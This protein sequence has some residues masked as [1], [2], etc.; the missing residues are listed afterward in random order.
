LL[1]S[2]TSQIS[3]SPRVAARSTSRRDYATLALGIG[4]LLLLTS[5]PY[6]YGSL[7]SP[8]DRHFMGIVLDVPDTAQYFAWLRAHQQALLVS[9]WMTPEPNQPAFFNLLW[10]CLGRLA[11]WTGMGLAES[12][13][14]LR[15]VAGAAFGFALFWLYGLLAE[16]RRER[17]M[18][19]VLVLVGGGIGWI[20]V[21]EKYIAKRSDL[22][23]PLDVQVAE[24]NALL[25]M[26]GYPHFLLAAAFVLA[27]FGLFVVGV[28]TGRM[29]VYL[30][31]G[32]LGLALGLQHAYDLIT[33]YFVLGAFVVLLW[34]SQKRFPL[35]EAIGLVLIGLVSSP[36]AAYFAYLTSHDLTW[37]QALAQFG[38]AG[39]YT[40]NPLH[41]LVVLGPQLP[42]ALAALPSLL[43]QRRDAD[44]LLFAWVVVGFGLLYIPTD[45]QIH[46]LNP[47]QAPLALLAVRVALKLAAA[48][49]AARLRRAAPA[50]LLLIAIPVNLYLFSWRFVD[51]SRHRAP[52]YLHQDEVAALLWLDQQDGDA[53]VLSSETVGQFVPALTG[54]RAVLAHWATTVNYYDK[55]AEVARFFAP[56]TPQTERAALLRHYSVDYVVYNIE[57][58]APDL[59][60][61]P[62]SLML[63]KVF[64]TPNVTIFKVT[65]DRQQ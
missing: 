26:I 51:L 58:G 28:R 43:R 10:F 37:Q 5:L 24:P 31:A 27:I 46:M 34:W 64:E 45:Y 29:S 56:K 65:I 38:N 3:A 16:D 47:Y 2:N 48:P 53:V 15:I 13:Q 40:P 41:L 57:E 30:L 23:F 62:R 11:L 33:V 17:W 54:K 39:V 50:L 19:T 52:Y 36:P 9:N 25:S 61:P 42:L 22:L 63:H 59:F 32:L 4:A 12:F 55:R 14:L 20:W 60:D 7:S 18:A 1:Q 8:A 49:G 44:L 21:I 6:L 35:R